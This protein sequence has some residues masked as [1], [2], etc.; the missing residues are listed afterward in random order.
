M[1]SNKPS[2]DEVEDW[3]RDGLVRVPDHF[4]QTVRSQI[5][6]QSRHP[7]RHRLAGVLSWC[8]VCLGGCL[9]IS[10]VLRYVFGIWLASAA[11]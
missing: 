9:G 7:L 8:G 2:F 11:G 1:Q 3:L 6:I 5:G 4:E 10:Q